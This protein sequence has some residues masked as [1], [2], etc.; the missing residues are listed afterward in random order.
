MNQK[1]L[2]LA[3]AQSRDTR[4][5]AD[6]ISQSCEY[7]DA[8]SIE[9]AYELAEQKIFDLVVITVAQPH[10]AL[11]QFVEQLNNISFGTKIII[12]TTTITQFKTSLLL[13]AGADLHLKQPL[14]HVVISH[15]CRKLLQMQKYKPG[16]LLTLGLVSL[17]PE[18]AHLYLDSIP[19]QLRRRE[20]DILA[21][22]FRFKNQIVT[23]DMI[24]DSVWGSI[25]RT[26]EKSTIDV[27]VRRLRMH[28]RNYGNCIQTVKGIGYSARAN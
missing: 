12:I 17:Q 9:R 6:S 25:D 7:T 24:I 26:P 23:R 15:Y 20:S 19:V 27:Y 1:I 3:L 14:N 5:A 21:C 13:A 18:T 11:I 28:M 8:F 4:L 10:H 22:L 2:H 16:A